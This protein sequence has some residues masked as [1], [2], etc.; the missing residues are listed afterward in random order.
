MNFS[1]CVPFDL[2]VSMYGL[3]RIIVGY[4]WEAQLFSDFRSI[5][6][7]YPLY[8]FHC[9]CFMLLLQIFRLVNLIVFEYIYFMDKE[10]FCV[11]VSFYQWIFFLTK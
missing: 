9:R 4:I 2:V 6:L 10:C 1:G 7:C 8:L 11:K 5:F 3:G